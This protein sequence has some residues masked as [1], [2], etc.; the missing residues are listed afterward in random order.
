MAGEINGVPLVANTEIMGVTVQNGIEIMG[1]VLALGSATEIFLWGFQPGNIGFMGYEQAC[2][3]NKNGQ[4]TQ[5]WSVYI[6]AQFRDRF[7]MDSSLSTPVL[8]LQTGRWYWATSSD[9]HFSAVVF[10]IG[11]SGSIADI[12][13]CG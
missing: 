4:P 1:K 6:D 12:V 9:P 3:I 7:Y 11:D 13:P 2:A 8:T 10:Q 5:P